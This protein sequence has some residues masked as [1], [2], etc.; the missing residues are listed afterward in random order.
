MVRKQFIAVVLITV[1]ITALQWRANSALGATMSFGGLNFSAT[2]AQGDSL[3]TSSAVS[4][5][6]WCDKSLGSKPLFEAEHRHASNPLKQLFQSRGQDLFPAAQETR[7]DAYHCD[8]S[9]VLGPLMTDSALLPL[10][11][12][13]CV[14]LDSVS[15]AMQ[16]SHSAAPRRW[17]SLSDS[18]AESK[19][20]Q[21]S[22]I[23]AAPAPNRR[24][25]MPITPDAAPSVNAPSLKTLIIAL[26]AI[27]GLLTLFGCIFWQYLRYRR[28]SAL[29]Q[30]GV[31]WSEEAETEDA[32]RA[33]QSV[34]LA[35][36]VRNE[37][38]RVTRMAKVIPMRA[39]TAREE[40]RRAA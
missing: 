38:R 18:R 8:V 13:V 27:G 4:E 34:L 33:A 6:E 21:V 17:S 26:P 1:A 31:V 29:I 30:E 36:L 16:P 39:A 2:G 11:D 3:A 7:N 15:M 28:S 22:S 23:S 35:S 10:S 20:P 5:A 25:A 14:A 9:R 12:N 19:E 32:D 40:I 37:N 24:V